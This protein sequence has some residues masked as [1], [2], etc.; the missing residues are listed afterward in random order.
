ML[1]NTW[2]RNKAKAKHKV[3]ELWKFRVEQTLEQTHFFLWRKY[4]YVFPTWIKYLTINHTEAVKENLAKEKNAP[5]NFFDG[6]VLVVVGLSSLNT[7]DKPQ[8]N[9]T[10]NLCWSFTFAYISPSL[11]YLLS[12]L[13]LQRKGQWDYHKKTC[14]WIHPCK[15]SWGIGHREEEGQDIAGMLKCCLQNVLPKNTN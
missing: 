4:T 2:E 12:L 1:F 14:H 5:L 13:F 8:R 3:A 15:T 10:P 6:V 7:S 9:L 11:W